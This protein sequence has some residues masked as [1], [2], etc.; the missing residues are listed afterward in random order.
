M[1]TRLRI[2]GYRSLLDFEIELKP[3]LNVIV[4]ANGT[5]KT[6][7]TSFLDFLGEFIDREINAA[8]AVAQ[9]ASAVFSKERFTES[10]AY[11]EFTIEGAIDSVD[12]FFASEK[13]T[14]VSAEYRYEAKISY[15]ANLPAVFVESELLQFKFENKEDFV[16]RRNTKVKNKKL[17]TRVDLSNENHPLLKHAFRWVEKSEEGSVVSKFITTRTAADVTALRWFLHEVPAINAVMQDLTSL[18]SINIEPS[19]ARRPSPVGIRQDVRSSG[20]GLAATLYRLKKNTYNDDLSIYRS[21]GQFMAPGQ[22]RDVYKSIISWAR[23]VNADIY[24]LEVTLNFTA[25]LIEPFVVF[26]HHGKH[27]RYSFNRI[28]DGTVKWLA[29][30]TVLNVERSL[31]TVEEPEN[32]L[33]P[34]MQES[35]VTLCRGIIE[36]A[37]GRTLVVSTHSPTILDCCT[38]DELIIF[39]LDDGITRASK[40]ANQ[41]ELRK[42]IQSGRFGLGYYYRTGGA[43][44]ADRG[45]S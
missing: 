10:A 33:H 11:F 39:E 31:S 21:Y 1:L 37:P 22:Q 27:E 35:F 2:D 7:F 32:F 41:A 26:L 16:V 29:L 38:P 20:E 25:A 6:N 36:R 23:E 24:D 34:F 5:G 12:E 4:G 44:G 9:G 15:L 45:N 40:V 8:I 14:N 17:V 3:G 19:V 43:Y 18:R 30:L 42:K 13:S 28:S